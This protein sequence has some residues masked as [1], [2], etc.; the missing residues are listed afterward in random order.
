MRKALLLFSLAVALLVSAQTGAVGLAAVPGEYRVELAQDEKK[1]GFIDVRNPLGEEVT[2]NVSVQGFRQA[3]NEGNLEFFENPDLRE[4]I[5]VDLDSFSL[6]ANETMRMYFMVDGT[7]LPKGDIFGAVFFTTKPVKQSGVSEAV[8]V[9]TLLSIVNGQPGERKAEV[10]ELSSSFLQLN[11]ELTGWYSIKNTSNN[12][13]RNGFYPRVD[14]SLNPFMVHKEQDSSLVFAG[15]ERKNNFSLDIGS[16]LGLY[17]LKVKH[18]DS[19]REKLVFVATGFWRYVVAVAFLTIVAGIVYI[20]RILFR[21]KRSS[22]R[23]GK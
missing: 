12:S 11:N 20:V 9:G 4:G 16:R 17:S 1:K 5:L 14:V 7:K 18:G 22:M 2:V 19:S 23:F 3:N 13:A 21:K 6:K 8:R 15:K 10:T